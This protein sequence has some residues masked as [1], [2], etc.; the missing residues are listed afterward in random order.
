MQ[1]K[2]EIV[3]QEGYD[4]FQFIVT[5]H[6]TIDS[7]SEVNKSHEVN[8]PNIRHQMSRERM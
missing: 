5:N 4:G 8:I 1:P 2:P 3:P 6:T 7:D